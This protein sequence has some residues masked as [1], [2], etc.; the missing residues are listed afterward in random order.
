VT[1]V[2]FHYN[3]RREDWGPLGIMLLH[4]PA[5]NVII[6][7]PNGIVCHVPC[8]SKVREDQPKIVMEA[9]VHSIVKDQDKLYLYG[10]PDEDNDC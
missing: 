3:A 1:R 6:P 2:W 8:Q 4:I 9:E 7:A 5:L 10:D